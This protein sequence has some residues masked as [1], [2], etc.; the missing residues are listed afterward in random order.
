MATKVLS[1]IATPYHKLELTAVKE[2]T[3]HSS[4]K[5]SCHELVNSTYHC[6]NCGKFTFEPLQSF[7]NHDTKKQ[8]DLTVSQRD[9]L[10][11]KQQELD[12]KILDLKKTIKEKQTRLTHTVEGIS[13]LQHDIKVLETKTKEETSQIKN[14]QQS[15]QIVK[16]ELEDLSERLFQEADSM[17]EL[18]KSQQEIL[19]QRNQQLAS[20]LES[21]QSQLRGTEQELKS[22]KTEYQPDLQQQLQQST[23][24]I[25][26]RAQLDTILMHGSDLGQL[27]MDTLEND[28]AL[29]D[30]ND[31]IQ[32]SQK[33]SLR[34]LHHLKYMKYCLRDDIMPCL[35]FGPNPKLSSKKIMEAILVKSC[36]VEQCPKGVQV[37]KQES[38]VPLW[39]R[40]SS[41][42][43][44]CQACGRKIKD[45]DSRQELLRYRFRISYFDEWTCIDRYCRDRLVSVIEFYNFIRQLRAGVYKHRSLHEL[46]QQI[47]RLKLQ[48]FLAR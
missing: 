47:I 14:I 46:Y 36:F 32:A 30:F 28:N 37:N 40:F 41:P 24:D 10:R 12:T 9:T 7:D 44:G 22:L 16:K 25:Y 2:E 35:R 43:L 48:M 19:K 42:F 6:S 21:T 15:Q 1:V 31:F 4:T 3:F 23:P 34:H 13:S 17:I 29:L 33:T 45:A 38:T 26:I 8:L 39:E 27:Y 20:E 5:C 11:H 18:E